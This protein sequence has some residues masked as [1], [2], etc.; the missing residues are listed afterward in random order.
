MRQ[1]LLVLGGSLALGLALYAAGT[2]TFTP[3]QRSFWSLQPMKKQPAP[4]VK[5]KA[6]VKNPIDAF[7]LAKLEEKDLAPN[8]AAD[9]V[10]LLRRATL[11]MTGLPPTQDE[12][13]QFQNDKSTNAWEKVIDRLLASLPGGIGLSG[14]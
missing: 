7:V 1:R 4:E 2:D 12:I 14:G 10:T 5:D 3:S 11:D 8:P 13:Q 9:R 6:W